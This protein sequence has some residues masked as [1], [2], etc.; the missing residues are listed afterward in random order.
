M[1]DD[2]SLAT[3]APRNKAAVGLAAVLAT[4]LLDQ[5][6]K[7]LIVLRV[8]YGTEVRVFRFLSFLHV[9]NSGV[10]F[11]FFRNH[12]SA[13]LLLVT[14]GVT[15]LVVWF[16]LKNSGTAL[17]SIGY[18]MILGGAIGNVIDRIA[19]GQVVDFIFLHW[20]GWTFAIFNVA[21]TAITLGVALLLVH[22]F[23]A[24]ADQGRASE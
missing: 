1:I 14:V 11:S 9:H 19:R 21:D 22:A 24:R 16:W 2:D 18:G 17:L 8:P 10:A 5:F 23:F 3:S 7:Y 4:V 12:D 15:L 20:Q 6:V 13:A